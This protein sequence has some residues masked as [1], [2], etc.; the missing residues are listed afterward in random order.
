MRNFEARDRR[1]G[2]YLEDYEEGDVFRHW[3]GKTI[4]E[5][6]NHL[7]CLLTM[8]TNPLHIDTQY[9]RNSRLYE[10]PVVVGS[11]VYSL[12]LGMSVPD[13]SGRALA[14]LGTSDL[15]HLEPVYPG[16][17]IYG[18]TTITNVRT[19]KSRP[20]A[21]ILTCETRGLNQEDHVVATFTR[22]ILLPKRPDDD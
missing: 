14:N 3:P 6:E 5:A 10:G 12:L 2:G 19:S 1:F 16:D 15:R 8:A 9:A 17:T 18:E 22:S 11:Y 13:I 21:G 7:F 20:G 4:T